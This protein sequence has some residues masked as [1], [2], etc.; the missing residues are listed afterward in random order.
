M[1]VSSQLH[2]Q[3]ILTPQ[4]DPWY[5]LNRS[6]GGP[7]AGLNVLEKRKM[8]CPCCKPTAA[9]SLTQLTA[10]AANQQL[11]YHSHNS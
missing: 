4:K 8:S 5:P 6:L 7:R 1:D 2:A 9:I 11:P 10:P 3:A